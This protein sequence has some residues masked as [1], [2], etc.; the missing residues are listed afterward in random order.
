MVEPEYL[1]GVVKHQR[2]R[3]FQLLENGLKNYFLETLE[4]LDMRKTVMAFG[5]QPYF[6]W[7]EP[8]RAT[9]EGNFAR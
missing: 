2:G 5:Q 1:F 4:L 8:T 9:S 3:S 7:F 6:Y